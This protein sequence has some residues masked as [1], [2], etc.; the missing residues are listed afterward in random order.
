MASGPFE[1]T[2]NCRSAPAGSGKGVVPWIKTTLKRAVERSSSGG[3]T[4]TMPDSNTD[5]EDTDGLAGYSYPAV[6]TKKKSCRHPKGRA[7]GFLL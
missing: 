1:T 5:E 2:G 4:F 3:S 7:A 6:N